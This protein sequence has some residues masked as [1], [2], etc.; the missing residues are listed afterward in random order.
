M[1]EKVQAESELQ[2][3]RA[4]LKK[5]AAGNTGGE[6]GDAV[7]TSS[8]KHYKSAKSVG[9][10]EN[11]GAEIDGTHGGVDGVVGG[12]GTNPGSRAGGN[13][14]TVRK[15]MSLAAV[16]PEASAGSMVSASTTSISMA[17]SSNAAAFGIDSTHLGAN[18]AGAGWAG[19]A[20]GGAGNAPWATV[21]GGDGGVAGGK[22]TGG[23]GGGGGAL[24]PNVIGQQLQRLQLQLQQQQ[25]AF[26]QQQQQLQASQSMATY[27]LPT[28]IMKSGD[29]EQ[30]R[31][32]GAGSAGGGTLADGG[33]REVLRVLFRQC[34][35]QKWLQQVGWREEIEER[36]GVAWTLDRVRATKLELGSNSLTSERVWGGRWAGDGDLRRSC[37]SEGCVVS[38]L[39]SL[40]HIFK[41]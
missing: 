22:V 11:H 18:G 37:S 36:Y 15:A 3:L 33:D 35:G 20:V 4:S 8:R 17:P 40:L 39:L 9:S 23:A 31:A 2:K 32:S 41:N 13:R 34:G 25:Q 24:D 10:N 21:A 29:E 14:H 6:S 1:L 26:R 16:K 38:L 19:V 28:G 7:D 30:R 12:N 27:S 5:N